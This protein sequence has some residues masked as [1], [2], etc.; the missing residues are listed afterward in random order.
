[1]PLCRTIDS[2]DRFLHTTLT[3]PISLRDVEGHLNV[4]FGMG[5]QA[6]PELIDAREIDPDGVTMRQ[7]ITTLRHFGLGREQ[8]APRALVVSSEPLF[9]IARIV[10]ALVSGWVQLGVFYDA[11][12]AREWLMSRMS[13][14]SMD[15]WREALTRSDLLHLSETA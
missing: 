10:A 5:V 3:S 9:A 4:V 6:C 1:M 8:F 7:V 13:P 14:V 2:R 15:A 12:L 11:D